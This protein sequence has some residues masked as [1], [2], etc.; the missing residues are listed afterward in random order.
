MQQIITLFCIA[1]TVASY[2]AI[3]RLYMRYNNPLLNIVVLSAALVIAVL[4]L[5]G[6]SYE[7]YLPS[8]DIMTI[9]LGPATVGLGLP[10]YRYRKLLRQYAV[11]IIS[12]VVTGSLLAMLSASLIA[13]LGGLPEDV[14]MSI[15]SKGVS[16][17][18][19][20]E[21]ANIYNGIPALA[22]AFVVAT[23]TLGSLMGAWFL[24]KIGIGNPIARGLALGTVSHAQGTAAALLEGEQQGAMAGLAMILAG[25]STAGFAP[26]VV[27]LLSLVTA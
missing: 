20:V 15:M 22:A 4:L 25:I 21:I 24:T 19:A 13:K 9:L 12:S 6:I 14:V 26:F 5:C 27:W 16:I 18:F 11:A 2:I 23:G 3:R 1:I 8:K 7:E 10:L 17:P